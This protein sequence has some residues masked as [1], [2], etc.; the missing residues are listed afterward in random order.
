MATPTAEDVRAEIKAWLEENWDPDLTVAEWWDILAR[1]GYAAPTFPEDAWGKGWGRDLAMV[2]TSAI[3]EHGAIGPPAGLGILL[4]APTIAAHGNERQKQEDL[5]RILNG[6]DAWCQ[7]FSEPGAG[8]DL[9]G[10]QT[11]GDQGR[12][13]V[14]HHRPEGV[15]LHRAAVQPRHADRAHRPE[16]AEAQGHQLLQVRHAAAG[17][18][19]PP[20]A[21]DDRSRDVQRGVHRQRPRAATRT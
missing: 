2:V 9:A 3:A 17:R 18:G 19:D 7:L 16:P 1:S 14:D 21:G 11:Q 13:R 20:A 10:L 5:L 6:Q 8:S 12:R 4:A 15:D